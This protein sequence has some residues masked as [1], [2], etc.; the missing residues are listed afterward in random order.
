MAVLETLCLVLTSI[1]PAIFSHP[2]RQNLFPGD[3]ISF[4]RGSQGM[5]RQHPHPQLLRKDLQ[6]LLS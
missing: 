2:F 4:P 3:H 6:F 5:Q 1:L